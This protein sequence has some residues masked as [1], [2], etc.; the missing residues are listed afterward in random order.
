MDEEEFDSAIFDLTNFLSYMSDPIR[1]ERKSLGVYV[2]LY[3]I[4]FS[5]FG[6]LLYREFKKDL[7]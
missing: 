1:E 7:R 2:I 6:Y 5:I 3:L 4:I